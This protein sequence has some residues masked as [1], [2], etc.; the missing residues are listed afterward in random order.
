MEEG[1]GGRPRRR[2][3]EGVGI[4]DSNYLELRADDPQ[5]IRGFLAMTLM[6]PTAYRPRTD[7]IVRPGQYD[8]VTGMMS[9]PP[10]Y[11]HPPEIIYRANA[12]FLVSLR[13]FFT[14][15]T[16]QR[17]E[18]IFSYCITHVICRFLFADCS[19]YFCHARARD[20]DDNK[21]LN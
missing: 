8:T 6:L 1:G 3:E 16:M 17:S 14:A 13:D 5:S 15:E 10:G 7:I 2:R 20:Y 11:S 19:N 12:G 9:A 18:I 4:S 21:V